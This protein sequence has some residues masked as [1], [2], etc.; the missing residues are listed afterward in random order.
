MASTVVPGAGFSGLY[1]EIIRRDALKGERGHQITVVSP[2]PKFFDVS[3]PGW[4]GIGQAKPGA[5]RFEQGLGRD[6]PGYD[7][8]IQVQC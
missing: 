8:L 5:A 4:A 6:R 7:F 3:S 2:Y 1:A